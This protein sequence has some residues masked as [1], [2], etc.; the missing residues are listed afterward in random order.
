[1]NKYGKCVCVFVYA[2]S[3]TAQKHHDTRSK[4]S[5]LCAS[6]TQRILAYSSSVCGPKDQRQRQRR[7]R[8]RPGLW[9]T[10]I[11]AD[12]V[13][14]KRTYKYNGFLCAREMLTKARRLYM[15]AS[16]TQPHIHTV[17]HLQEHLKQHA[18]LHTMYV[19]SLF[20]RAH[21]RNIRIKYNWS[22]KIVTAKYYCNHFYSAGDLRCV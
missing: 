7:P 1:M 8:R 2:A 22:T 13:L 16:W 9:V 18:S 15:L 4:R 11:C 6:E 20:G 17:Q 21:R 19:A 5:Q 12:Y 14:R 10:K 3:C